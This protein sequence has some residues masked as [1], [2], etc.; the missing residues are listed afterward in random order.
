MRRDNVDIAAA[1]QQIRD[2]EEAL[3]RDESALD[4]LNAELTEQHG[5][6]YPDVRT[7][8]CLTPGFQCKLVSTCY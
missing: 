2:L 6:D 1:E 4:S 7:L 3:R 8:E 5:Q